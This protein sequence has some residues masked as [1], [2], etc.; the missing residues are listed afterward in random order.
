MDE[1]C[2]QSCSEDMIAIQHKYISE[3]LGQQI[4][5]CWERTIIFVKAKEISNVLYKEYHRVIPFKSVRMKRARPNMIANFFF[6]RACDHTL[7]KGR[8]KCEEKKIGNR[9]F[10]NI[11]LY[12][13]LSCGIKTDFGY[14]SERRIFRKGEAVE[15]GKFL[16]HRQRLDCEAPATGFVRH[17]T[18]GEMT[19]KP[20][21]GSTV[22]MDP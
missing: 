11:L 15:K 17:R 5:G 4:G 19:R 1:T 9:H 22:S 18:C 8:K 2:D 14:H 6:V 20:G 12:A 3:L 7:R 13:R 16:D 10:I 21:R